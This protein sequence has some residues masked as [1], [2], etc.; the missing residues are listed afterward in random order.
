MKNADNKLSR[1]HVLLVTGGAAVAAGAVLASP[2]RTSV[3]RG[4]R[5]LAVAQPW[6]RPMLSLA[7]ASYD[8]WAAQ[9][10]SV[11]AIGGA[12]GMRLAGVQ[13]LNSGGVRPS[14]LVRTQAFVA[15]FDPIGGGTMAGDLIYT[16]NHPQYG[17]LAIFLQASADARTPA[18]MLAVFN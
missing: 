10:G 5:E 3:E 13:A 7:N 17:P 15:M 8:E 16:A 9:V 14:S 11:F 12:T 4:A 6:L 1:R 2:L 18:R